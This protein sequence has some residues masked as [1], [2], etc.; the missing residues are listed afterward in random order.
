MFDDAGIEEKLK[1]LGVSLKH[2]KKAAKGRTNYYHCSN[3]TKY[4][5]EYMVSV[6]YLGPN[7][8][9]LS[10]KGSHDHSEHQSDF[11]FKDSIREKVKEGVLHGLNS[12]Q[13]RLVS[14]VLVLCTIAE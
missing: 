13:V 2:S 8:H 5:C 4:K 10:E 3:K 14:N 1:T 11:R 7:E 9:Y 6:A 12:K